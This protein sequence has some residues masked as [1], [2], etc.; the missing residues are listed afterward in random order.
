MKQ[1]YDFYTS[2]LLSGEVQ[3]AK[4]STKR[5]PKQLYSDRLARATPVWA[6]LGQ[7]YRVYDE[8]SDMRAAGIPATVDHIYPLA[9]LDV[10]GLHVVENLH[11]VTHDN[12]SRKRNTSAVIPSLPPLPSAQGDLF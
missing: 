9:G 5:S 4:S 3:V 1:A 7:I 11:I 12:N 6:D 2:D 10:C 8:A